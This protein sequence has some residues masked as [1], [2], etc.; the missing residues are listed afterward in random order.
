[1]CLLTNWY[2][3]KANRLVITLCNVFTFCKFLRWRA[4]FNRLFRNFVQRKSSFWSKKQSIIIDHRFLRIAKRFSL[5]QSRK[6]LFS[7]LTRHWVYN[8]VTSTRS[9]RLFLLF[10]W[11]L[12]F[13]RSWRIWFWIFLSR[14][15]LTRRLTL[16]SLWKMH[17][18]SV[19]RN[20]Q[21]LRRF[22]HFYEILISISSWRR[23]LCLFASLSHRS[24][25]EN[26]ENS[27]EKHEN[28]IY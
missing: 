20:L 2:E 5:W 7:S 18:Q 14:F 10:L 26:R 8:D 24:S 19:Y 28:C 6:H 3:N 11:I 23:L 22:A 21:I 12:S 1:L 13:L 4:F 17:E 25:F 27:Y 9:W 15:F 16:R